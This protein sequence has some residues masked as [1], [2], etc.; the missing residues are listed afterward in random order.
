VQQSECTGDGPQREEFQD[1]LYINTGYLAACLVVALSSFETH[2]VLVFLLATTALCK[3][4]TILKYRSPNTGTYESLPLQI[5]QPG[6]DFR[7]RAGSQARSQDGGYGCNRRHA[8]Q[9]SAGL[10]SARWYGRLFLR[11]H[12]LHDR[13][14]HHTPLGQSVSPH[15]F[16]L[17]QAPWRAK[18]RARPGQSSLSMASDTSLTSSQP[19]QS[20]TFLAMPAEIRN[21]IYREVLVFGSLDLSAKSATDY[22]SNHVRD[23]HWITTRSRSPAPCA[24]CVSTGRSTEKLL[25]SSMV[26][27]SSASRLPA[28]T[29]S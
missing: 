19:R 14:H 16:S 8:R 12:R 28:V 18:V 15:V 24:S 26:R 11:P 6:N 21:V 5:L 4:C 1:S 27:T 23:L 9:E 7:S 3:Q 29:T 25:V 22:R 13:L 10:R 20:I 17:P 2:V